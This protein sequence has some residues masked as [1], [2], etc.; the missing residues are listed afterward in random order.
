MSQVPP[1]DNALNLSEETIQLIFED[2][3][4]Y[5]EPIAQAIVKYLVDGGDN[6]ILPQLDKGH[7]QMP[8]ERS[9][10]FDQGIPYP[11]YELRS[12]MFSSLTTQDVAFYH[13]LAQAYDIEARNLEMHRPPLDWLSLFLHCLANLGSVSFSLVQPLARSSIVTVPMIEELLQRFGEPLDTLARLVFLA[14]VRQSDPCVVQR[15]AWAGAS[16]PEFS[17]YSLKHEAIAQAALRHSSVDQRIHALEILT[18]CQMSPVPFASL[19]V[20][21]ATA[22]SKTERA[23]A[24][25]VLKQEAIAM[26]PFVQA[27]VQTGKA[28]ER[29]HAAKVLADLAGAEARPFLEERLEVEQTA[30]VRDAIQYVLMDLA[31]LH[32]PE[33]AIALSPLPPIALDAPLPLSV[34]VAIE[35]TLLQLHQL[36]QETYDATQSYNYPSIPVPQPPSAELIDRTYHCLQFGTAAECLALVPLFHYL[37][38]SQVPAQFAQLLQ[39]PE[40]E[41]IHVARL[42]LLLQLLATE[43]QGGTY[44]HQTLPNAMHWKEAEINTALQRWCQA[45]QPNNSLRYLAASLEALGLDGDLFAWKM[46][47]WENSPFW[48]W[49]DAAIAEYFGERLSVIDQLVALPPFPQVYLTWEQTARQ[50]LF[51][52]LAIFPHLPTRFIPL[53]WDIALSGLQAEVPL[54]QRCLDHRPRTLERLHQ[55]VNHSDPAI[56]VTVIQWLTRLQD[57]TAI[58]LFQN[59]LRGTITATVRDVLFRSLEKLG[60]SITEFLDPS[61]L[62]QE[63]QAGLSKGIPK[64]LSWFSF[65]ALP[66]VHWQDTEAPVATEIL[67]WFVVQSY[68]QKNAEPSPVLRQYVKL[69][70]AEERQQFGQ[71]VLESW[72]AQ[73][74]QVASAVKEKGILAVAGACGGAAMVP[75]I[76]SYLKTYFGKRLPQCIALLNML[77]WSD[78]FAAIQLLLAIANRFRTQKI[79]QA[80]QECVTQLA[81]RQGWTLTEL[82]DRT[83][84]WCGLAE[85]GTLTLD[86]GPR[87]L[88]VALDA[89]CQMQLTDEQGKVLKALPAARKDDDA[90]R[91]K[92]A[93]QQW[94]A[95]KKQLTLVRSQQEARLYEALCTQRS[96]SFADWELYLYQHPVVGRLCQR[97]IWAVFEDAA[98]PTQTFCP[99]PNQTLV[100]AAGRVVT[101]SPDAMV[102]LAQATLLPKAVTQAWQQY[103]SQAQLSPLFDKWAVVYPLPATSDQVIGISDFAGQSLSRHR[104]RQRAMQQGYLPFSDDAEHG[105]IGDYRKR[106]EDINLEA[107]I[108]FSGDH[109]VSPEDFE[110]KLQDLYFW[111]GR[112]L[113]LADV[114]P[115]LLSIVWH[116]VQAIAAVE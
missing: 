32:A 66:P 44:P 111:Q 67:T 35:S 73:D 40:L 7:I 17:A 110:V 55:L 98:E 50:Q 10:P 13:R 21:C 19:L 82:A 2:F 39:I 116:E 51:R 1:L 27:K 78:D 60:A 87:Q 4:R 92:V 106:F 85:D 103:W 89:E 68:Q 59:A 12:R 101:V 95:T 38:H 74:T 75:V 71:V 31:I 72:I 11:S 14:D 96:W 107:V 62:L 26:M 20:D 3:G 36:A 58:P 23:I 37:I 114:P 48:T 93:K 15:V 76:N 33:V 54:A 57:H 70:Q 45:R 18:I 6:S 79:Q 112:P 41:V 97:L 88:T 84:P 109:P 61:E 94:T 105:W 80:A 81:E 65:E 47:C 42:L 8:D 5:R 9:V 69:W 102:R 90:D 16:L 115:V 25:E 53:L 49:G 99:Q 52:I 46:L 100:D 83:I 28:S 108:D 77:V 29:A 22:N 86:Y 63:A 104:L 24:L 56:Q 113:P 64:A 30:T 91:V 34:R 43:Y